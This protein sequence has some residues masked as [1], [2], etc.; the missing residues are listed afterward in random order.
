MQGK[1]LGRLTLAFTG[2]RQQAHC[3]KRDHT[4]FSFV[5]FFLLLP[6]TWDLQDLHSLQ[7]YGVV[8]AAEDGVHVAIQTLE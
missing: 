8:R 1:V 5:G 2:C 3:R 6:W 4:N 7:L